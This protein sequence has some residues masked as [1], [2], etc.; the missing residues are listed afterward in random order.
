MKEI[1][2]YSALL[3][4]HVDTNHLFQ[5]TRTNPSNGMAFIAHNF[6]RAVINEDHFDGEERWGFEPNNKVK[7]FCFGALPVLNG[8]P[9]QGAMEHLF[10]A[11]V[12]LKAG[13]VLVQGKDAVLFG[14]HKAENCVDPK[15]NPRCMNS[16]CFVILK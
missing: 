4:R 13:D 11:H 15:P 1:L 7:D 2:L 6:V 8:H 16:R 14:S 12:K 5:P 9:C 3:A 10:N